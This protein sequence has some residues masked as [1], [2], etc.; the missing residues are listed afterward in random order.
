MWTHPHSISIL[1]HWFL[2]SAKQEFR[3]MSQTQIQN[4]PAH[5]GLLPCAYLLSVPSGFDS[6]RPGFYHAPCFDLTFPVQCTCAAVSQWLS[7]TSLRRRISSWSGA[8]GSFCL[9]FH[10]PVISRAT[11]VPFSLPPLPARLCNTF[12]I[13]VNSFVCIPC[14]GSPLSALLADLPKFVF[15]NIA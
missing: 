5:S 12:V 3:L 6:E 11:R 8:Y 14:W 9:I 4:P 7:S 2:Y 15:S 1:S 10:S 13:Q